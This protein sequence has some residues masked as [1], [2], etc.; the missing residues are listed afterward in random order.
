MFYLS[1]TTILLSA[2]SHYY[3]CFYLAVAR[4]SIFLCKFIVPH[5]DFNASHAVFQAVHGNRGL[6]CSEMHIYESH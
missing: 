3:V 6:T 4:Q 5:T 2:D 1:N